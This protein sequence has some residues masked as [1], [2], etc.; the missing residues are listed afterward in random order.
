MM[1]LLRYGRKP[2]NSKQSKV[3]VCV[4][5]TSS[6]NTVLDSY[7]QSLKTPLITHLYALH[8]NHKTVFV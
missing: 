5:Q 4:L 2:K 3:S 1:C 6:L 8:T 7:V